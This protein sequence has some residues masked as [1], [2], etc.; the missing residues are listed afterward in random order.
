MKKKLLLS[1]LDEELKIKEISD[2]SLNGLQVDNKNEEIRKI[3]FAVDA[4][5]KTIEIAISQR[6]DMLFVHHGLLWKETLPIVNEHYE[7]IAALIRGNLALYAA[8]LPLDMHPQ[9]GN[10]AVMAKELGLKNI[11]P[12]GE[13]KGVKIGFIGESTIGLSAEHCAQKLNFTLDDDMVLLNFG[14][15]INKNIAIVSGGA[16]SLLKEAADK[17]ADLYITGEHSHSL[18]HFAEERK[19]NMLCGGHYKSEVFGVKAVAK[20]LKEK[21]KIE[22]T[23]I[24]LPSGM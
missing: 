14:K 16:S 5:M 13:Y 20:F 2:S 11:T 19:I 17:N 3:V 21:C 9:L 6:A 8:H 22:A 7:R 18:Y 23:F 4:C 24:D 12:F 10:N 1:I 15:H